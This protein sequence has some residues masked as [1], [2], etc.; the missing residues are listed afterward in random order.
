M[1]RTREKLEEVAK[2]V[3]ELGGT[4]HVHPCDLSDLEDIE[5]LARGG[6]SRST[7]ASTS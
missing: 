4:A 6:A 5:R 2:E 7:A 3:E 1:S